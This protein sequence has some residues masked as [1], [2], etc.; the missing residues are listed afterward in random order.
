[1]TMPNPST[2]QPAATSSATRMLT[3][4]PIAATATSG[5]SG[6]NH[7]ELTTADGIRPSADRARTH[8]WPICRASGTCRAL[9]LKV[10][11]A[12][13]LAGCRP[14]RR[15]GLSLGLSRAGEVVTWRPGAPEAIEQLRLLQPCWHPWCS[16]R[17]R[18]REWP[19][20]I[21]RRCL[22]RDDAR[23]TTIGSSRWAMAFVPA[24]YAVGVSAAT[25]SQTSPWRPWTQSARSSLPVSALAVTLPWSA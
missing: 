13:I 11:H 5:T 1:M 18:H 2:T 3:H 15:P 25:L 6:Q 4:W 24:G 14:S 19:G 23:R 9:H 17:S 10:A 22:R 21:F 7:G 20:K 16:Q 12:R 8:L